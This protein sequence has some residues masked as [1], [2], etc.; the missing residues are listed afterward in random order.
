VDHAWTENLTVSTAACNIVL[1]WLVVDLQNA[2]R[3]EVG[4]G[5]GSRWRTLDYVHVG[6]MLEERFCSSSMYSPLV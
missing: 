6:F 2:Q 1:L 3:R 5:L 4:G